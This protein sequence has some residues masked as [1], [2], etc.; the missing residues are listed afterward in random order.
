ML[1]L[2]LLRMEGGGGGYLLPQYLLTFKTRLGVKHLF[3]RSRLGIKKCEVFCKCLVY[4]NSQ[5]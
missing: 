2:T 5:I 3:G 4:N 1:A